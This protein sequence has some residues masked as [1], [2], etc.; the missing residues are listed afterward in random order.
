MWWP[1]AAASLL[2]PTFTDGSI[3]TYGVKATTLA[4]IASFTLF[5]LPAGQCT[6][7]WPDGTAFPLP[8]DRCC[9]T[10]N[11]PYAADGSSFAVPAT[12]DMS[13]WN[14]VPPF[15]VE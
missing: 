6:G 11:Q 15:H 8:N 14:L 3:L 7:P 5:H 4:Q 2:P 13:G 10:W 12:L 1:A 9:F